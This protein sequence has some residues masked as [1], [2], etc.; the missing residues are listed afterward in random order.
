[1]KNL[2][3]LFSLLAASFSHAQ[4]LIEDPVSLK[5]MEVQGLSFSE[6]LFEKKLGNNKDL[7]NQTEY[8][9]LVAD[10][11]SDLKELQAVDANLGPSMKYSHRL[12]DV[13]WLHSS[14]AMFELVGIVNRMDRA[15]FN[16]GTCGELRLIYRL[17]YEKN[18]G[19]ALINSRLPM[20]ANAVFKLPFK[21]SCKEIAAH[22]TQ[23]STSTLLE[24]TKKS[25]LKSLELNLQSV[26]WPSTVRGDMG[27]HAEYFMRV[28][29]FADGK[30]AAA[31][32]ENT[33]NV[34]ALNANS[35]LKEELLS[36]LLKPQQIRALD[37]GT[38][39]IPEKFLARKV[40]SFALHGMNRLANRPFDSVFKKED[41]QTIDYTKL[42]NIYGASS[43]RRR[44]NDMSCAGC[45]QG[46]TIAGFHFLG[47]D[48]A[49][50]VFAN[51][52]FSSQSPHMMDEIPRRR[53]YW[54]AILEVKTADA[55]RPFS[56]R[57][58]QKPGTLNAHCGL[59][60]EY[61][62]WTCAAGLKCT[63][64]VNP[65]KN[66]EIGE[67]LPETPMAGNPCEPGLISQTSNAHKDSLKPLAKTS[68]GP[69]M[70]CETTRV[71]FPAGM[72]SGGC[73]DLKPGE[74]C[75]AIAV[76]VGFNNCLAKSRPFSQCLAEN[77]RPGVLQACDDQTA[78]RADYICMKTA[79]GKG[80][81]I[82][83]YF[84]FQLRVDGHPS[85]I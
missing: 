81:C 45:H 12:F 3:L 54:T 6:V 80:A 37:E 34:E 66:I 35:A 84:L 48:H 16:P 18:Q 13:R 41:F 60:S 71:G 57:D 22:W 65:E 68:C 47:R 55:S 26:R 39:N 85:P 56:E 46:R 75:G 10:L 63:P 32:L 17:S 83:P 77:T 74:T 8:K 76:L 11:E 50:T 2:L 58:P 61:K 7:F 79:S 30:W 44:L 42:K 69:G 21:N 20:T 33:P 72:C 51:S 59:S 36:W 70:F 27:G 38:I 53:K 52:I 73:G 31:P 29:R 23:V 1:M 24:W 5:S 78:C 25:H 49:K 67:C 14:S 4:L 62:A 64:V 82:P 40:S 19:G 15:V 43:F 9:A 28:Y